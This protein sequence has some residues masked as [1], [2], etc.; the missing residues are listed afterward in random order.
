M[1]NTQNLEN[2]LIR[3]VKWGDIPK[4][5]EYINTIETANIVI[6]GIDTYKS[7]IQ[8]YEKQKERE[9]HKML[10]KGINNGK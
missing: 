2:Q 3:C 5:K 10:I 4:L 1:V 7:H 9:E 6:P 8:H